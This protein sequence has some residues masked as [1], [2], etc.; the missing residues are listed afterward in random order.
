MSH[1]PPQARSWAAKPRQ[2][3]VVWAHATLGPIAFLG[4]VILASARAPG[5]W[6]VRRQ[7]LL[8]VLAESGAKSLPIVTVVDALVGAI[9]AFVGAVQLVKFGAGIFVADLVSIAVTRE[10]AA[11]ITAV[12][13][14]GRTASSFAAELATMQADEEIDALRVLGIDPLS[15][16]VL[17]RIFALVLMMPLLYV[18]GCLASLG[19]GLLVSALMLDISAPAYI[20]R[21]LKASPLSFV[22]LGL[23]KTLF[24]GAL[25]GLSACYTGLHASRDAAGVGRATTKAVVTGIVGV[26]A[27]DALFA[28]CANAL[29]I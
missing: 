12:V 11:V 24:F 5:R 4:E 20:E 8:R 13:V 10:M 6:Q 26:I 25:I 19:G 16:L 1:P 27:L 9:L 28:V 7:D 2:Q 3:A 23:T 29:N 18:Y 21:A 17:P 22:M 14:A 15:Y